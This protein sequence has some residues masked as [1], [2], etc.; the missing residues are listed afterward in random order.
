MNV[1]GTL[2]GP[3]ELDRLFREGT[4]HGLRALAGRKRSVTSTESGVPIAYYRFVP[5]VRTA[6]TPSCKIF[7]FDQ[8]LPVAVASFLER[9]VVPAVVTL[10]LAGFA[11]HM[12]A[13][14]STARAGDAIDATVAF[15][16]EKPTAI[17]WLR[18][19]A[20]L[21]LAFPPETRVLAR[22]DLLGP[23]LTQLSLDYGV[24][25]IAGPRR[26][27]RSHQEASAASPY[28]GLSEPEVRS[29]IVRGRRQP[30]RVKEEPV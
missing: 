16:L 14:D 2:L 8:D 26:L 25:E 20:W 13:A 30:T 21:R 9:G 15:T 27:L 5:P 17:E 1:F 23:S 7:L 10:E 28:G 12:N 4:V 3:G 18:A 24:D 11:P 22:W 29:L 6:S 19:L